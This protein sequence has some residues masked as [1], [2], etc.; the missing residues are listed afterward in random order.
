M[1]TM[2]SASHLLPLRK[3]TFL[4]RIFCKY[5]LMLQHF[6]QKNN[7]IIVRTHV[8]TQHPACGYKNSVECL[9]ANVLT[10]STGWLSST[11][12]QPISKSGLVTV[13]TEFQYGSSN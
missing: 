8:N 13:V 4:P 10:D 3:R 11:H 5:V 12:A 9:N 2:H 6:W 1:H 7:E